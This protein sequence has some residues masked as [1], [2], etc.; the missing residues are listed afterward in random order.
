VVC[1]QSLVVTAGQAKVAE[2]GAVGAQSVCGEQLGDEALFPEQLAHQA[3][4]RALVA[5]ALDQH[6][7]DLTFMVDG[8]PKVHPP[9][10]NANHHLVEMPAIARAGALA[11][12]VPHDSG[13]ER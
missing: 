11:P 1:P 2:R 4:R 10:G 13:A 6:V 5:P 8:A 9:A 7:E 12:E 3:P